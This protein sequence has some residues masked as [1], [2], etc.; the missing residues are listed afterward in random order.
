[1]YRSDGPF[2]RS[3]YSRDFVDSSRRAKLGCTHQTSLTVR[4]RQS[5]ECVQALRK[6]RNFPWVRSR[7]Y[8]IAGE[9]VARRHPHAYR[10][11]RTPGQPPPPIAYA[12]WVHDKDTTSQLSNYPNYIRSYLRSSVHDLTANVGLSSV[13]RDCSNSAIGHGI[14][15]AGWNSNKIWLPRDS[16]DLSREHVQ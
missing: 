12:D 5:A 14:K 8:V 1:M 3:L 15:P 13:E 9:R 6:R 16:L 11:Q 2:Q 7:N 10:R 4:P